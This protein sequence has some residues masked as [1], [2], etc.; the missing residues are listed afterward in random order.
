MAECL[1][2]T[3]YYYD[4]IKFINFLEYKKKLELSNKLGLFVSITMIL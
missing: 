3:N 4:A 1:I 2:N